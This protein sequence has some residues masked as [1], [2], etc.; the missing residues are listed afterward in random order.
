MAKRV[1]ENGYSQLKMFGKYYVRLKNVYENDALAF[2]MSG[3]ALGER[4]SKYQP[5]R[6][7]RFGITE[8]A[9]KLGIS[10]PFIGQLQAIVMFV[11]KHLVQACDV[12]DSLDAIIQ[13][14][15]LDNITLGKHTASEVLRL[16]FGCTAGASPTQSGTAITPSEPSTPGA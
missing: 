9:K 10:G 5:Y 1:R 15:D 14:Q 2:A 4:N 12:C 3:N 8:I 6:K 7:V 16:Y 11:Q 13:S